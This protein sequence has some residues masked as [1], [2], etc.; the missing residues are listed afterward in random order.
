MVKTY[1]PPTFGA[2]QFNCVHCQ[3]YA[4]QS[5]VTVSEN[6]YRQGIPNHV[7]L[8]DWA[9]CTC[10][11]CREKSV[12]RCGTMVF[13][14]SATAPFAHDEMPDDCKFDYNEAREIVGRS[15]R[16]AC[17][18]IR[19]AVQKLL[20]HLGEK[21]DRIDQDIAS[22]VKKGL[23][24]TVQQAL[25]YCRV[26]GNNAVHPGEIDINDDPEVAITLFQLINHIVE[27]MIAH[28]KQVSA[29]FDSLPKGAKDAIQKRDGAKP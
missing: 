23:P 14:A 6:V 7:E 28:P 5:W 9:T 15:P 20:A 10:V 13:P 11:H 29:I 1:Y 25:D 16:A 19:L 24:P 3:V 26:I 22:L 12:W 21:G 4:A 8:T 2:K 17:A 18:L 27:A